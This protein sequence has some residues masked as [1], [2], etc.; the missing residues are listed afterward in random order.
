MCMHR[1]DRTMQNQEITGMEVIVWIVSSHRSWP[2]SLFPV[3][4]V[5]S[6]PTHE[7]GSA[8]QNT[9][10]KKT[11]HWG[12]AANTKHTYGHMYVHVFT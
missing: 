1:W 2:F 4:G 12:L 10:I 11:K 6:D 3:N 8:D 5:T 7:S 9:T